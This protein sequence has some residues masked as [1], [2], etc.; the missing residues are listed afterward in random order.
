[1]HATPASFIAHVDSRKKYEEIATWFVKNE[2]DIFIGGG[3]KYFDRRDTD[4]LD[5]I[6]TLR[7]K[8]YIV[9]DYF[10]DDLTKIKPD[11][12]K[13]FAFFTADDNPLTVEQGRDY[14]ALA[15]EIATDYLEAASGD[16]GFF[17]MIEGSQID[18]GGHANNSNYI[19]TEMLDFDKTIGT[20]FDFAEQN[21]KT[22]VVITADHET[23][24]YSII[25]GSKPDSLVTAFTTS[26]HTATLI[27]VYSFGPGAG[28]FSG[29]YENTE[30]YRKMCKA[31]SLQ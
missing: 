18:W 28:I 10:N 30:I 13:K 26:Y 4:T 31:L 17:L 7:S 16:K 29:I 14:L 1:M 15:A 11:P 21:K 5:L 20:V 22:L 19:V 2:V 6:R 3:K 8:D 9:Q 23:G 27:P 25:L 12:S 24:G